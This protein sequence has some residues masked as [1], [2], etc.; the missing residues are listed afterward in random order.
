MLLP[1]GHIH[2]EQEPHQLA[3][4]HAAS[5]CLDPQLQVGEDWAL[6]EEPLL[7]LVAELVPHCWTAAVLCLDSALL[8]GLSVA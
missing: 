1:P 4:S 3:H 7:V 6:R 8:E 2:V 5:C